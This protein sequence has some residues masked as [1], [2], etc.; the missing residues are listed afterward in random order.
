MSFD[1]SSDK[2]SEVFRM[3]LVEVEDMQE[4]FVN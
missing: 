2:V 3:L 1:N 4:G